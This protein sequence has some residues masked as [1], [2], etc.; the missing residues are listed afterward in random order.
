MLVKLRFDQNSN[1]HK[2]FKKNRKNEKPPHIVLLCHILTIQVDKQGL[3]GFRR[4]IHVSQ[5]IS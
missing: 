3:H 1:E 5:V 4:D 2:K